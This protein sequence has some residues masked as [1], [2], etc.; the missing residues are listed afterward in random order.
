MDSKRILIV[1]DEESI[2]SVLKR[3]IEKMNPSYDVMTCLDG[4]AAL[5]QLKRTQFDLVVTDYRMTG[6]TGL[7]LL[8][9]AKR[10]SPKTQVIM[11]TAFGDDALE[12]EVRKQQAY[13]YLTKPLELNEFRN[14]VS[15]ALGNLAISRPG[16]LVLSDKRYQELS[17]LVKSLSK[18][19]GS[20]SIFLTDSSG[21]MIVQDG[22]VEN[23]PVGE[24][25]SL[26]SGSMAGLIEAGILLDKDSGTVNMNY[27][28][29]VHHNMYAIN[30]G[31]NLLLIVLIEKNAYSS[32]LG[33]VW[34]YAHRAALSLKKV[35]EEKSDVDNV[36]VFDDGFED[37]F[38][39]EFDKLL[40]LDDVAQELNPP[41]ASTVTLPANPPI[42]TEQKIT[43]QPL[44][45][46]KY[47]QQYIEKKV[48]AEQRVPAPIKAA[49]IKAVPIKAVPIKAAPIKAVPVKAA[50]TPISHSTSPKATE[51]GEEAELLTFEEAIRRGLISTS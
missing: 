21:Q 26:L 33:S 17:Q 28:E 11:I 36:K 15:K 38:D 42:R 8:T 4:Y 13:D 34:Y 35:F 41:L 19:I 18:D 32:K 9:E 25:S 24:I 30:V 29:G 12:A 23:I 49:P 50:P 14:V 45:Q 5:Q 48:E 40:G 51:P 7:E 16:I 20:L 44:K 1:D 22:V 10:I 3:G 47:S 46:S 39:D 27:R 43:S 6:M 31:S 37:A 2:L